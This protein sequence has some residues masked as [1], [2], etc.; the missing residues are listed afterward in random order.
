MWGLTGHLSVIYHTSK[1]PPESQE[2][3]HCLE[4]KCVIDQCAWM[5]PL[6]VKIL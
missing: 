2:N 3:S 5:D 1:C 6:G 4:I